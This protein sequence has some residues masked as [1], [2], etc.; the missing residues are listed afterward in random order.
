MA[1]K[2][3]GIAASY[4]KFLPAMNKVINLEDR[5][6]ICR[7]N[8]LGSHPYKPGS[9]ELNLLS[10]YI[11]YLSRDTPIQVA[12]DGP[13][14]KAIQRGKKSFFTKAGQLNFSCA[15]CHNAA[16][17][18]WLRGQSLAEIKPGGKHSYTASTW[19]KHFIA[20]HDLGLISLQQRIRHCQAVTR[21]LPLKLGSQE[22]TEMELYLTS[23]A[24]GKPMLAPTKSKLRG[25]D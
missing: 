1:G 16:A 3:D 14:A 21:T 7:V 2:L 19:P 22:Y 24:N 10:S 8:A 11:K 12:T 23:L 20:G 17:G 15:D 25:E 18:K 4:P 9:K 13:A 6:N 5:I